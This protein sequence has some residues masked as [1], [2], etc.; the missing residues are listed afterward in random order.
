[1]IT[2]TAQLLWKPL[3]ALLLTLGL[4]SANW[5]WVKQARAKRYIEQLKRNSKY[6][7][8]SEEEALKV[9]RESQ[10]RLEDVTA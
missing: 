9:L 8:G 1:M 2:G 7:I 6:K 5:S 4:V 3:A 10:Q